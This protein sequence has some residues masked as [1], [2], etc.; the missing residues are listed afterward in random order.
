MT[1]E[2]T[3]LD[4]RLAHELDRAR[5]LLEEMGDELATDIEVVNSHYVALQ[6]VDIVMQIVGHIANVVR[7]EDQVDAVDNIGMH[8]L[9]MKLKAVLGE[10]ACEKAA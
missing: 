3:P 6:T 4:E 8:E 5:L 1:R 7:A 9:K 10:E 2:V